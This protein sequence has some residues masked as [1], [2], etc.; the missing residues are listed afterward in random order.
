MTC[1][2]GWP[3]CA[4]IA[5]GRALAMEPWLNE[6]IRRRRAVH[7][8][9]SGPPRSHGVP[10]SAVKI[11]SS[12]ASRSMMAGDVLRVHRRLVP[13]VSRASSSSRSRALPVVR[14][15]P[16]QVRAVGLGRQQRQQRLDRVLDRADQ[17][18]LDRRAAAERSPA[19]CRPGRSVHV[20]GIELLVGEVGA[21]H[22]QRVAVLHR[23]VAGREAEQPGH[24]RRRRDCRTRRTPCRA[25]ACTTG[26]FSASASAM[27]LVM[28]AG[29]AAPAEDGDPLAGVEHVRG[30]ASSD[31]SVRPDHRRA[32]RIGDRPSRADGGVGAGTSRPAPRRRRPRARSTRRA[33]RDLQ[34]ARAAARGADQSR[35][36]AALAEQ[37]LRV[38]LLEVAAADLGARDVRGDRQHRHPAAVRVEQPVDQVQVARSAAAR[39]HRELAGQRGLGGR[40][41][42]RRL[43]VADVDPGD[44]RRPGAAR[45]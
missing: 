7:L 38:G 35:S 15:H 39:A 20:V 30:R 40:R 34:D 18:E 29:A 44:R 22:Q 13:A 32:A 8:S 41:E 4:P 14:G 12:A 33:H 1:R 2:P 36:N 25:S 9:G 6:P 16:V 23:P 19:R 37:L 24:A 17:A 27:Q 43:L 3:A 31:A 42:R 11:A 26:A 10:T 45:R 5:C 28:R 21:E